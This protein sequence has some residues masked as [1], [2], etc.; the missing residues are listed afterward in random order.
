MPFFLPSPLQLLQ[1]SKTTTKLDGGATTL[2]S[3]ILAQAGVVADGYRS[4]ENLSKKMKKKSTR[5]NLSARR[6][7][8][9]RRDGNKKLTRVFPMQFPFIRRIYSPHCCRMVAGA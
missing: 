3:S 2:C 9:D 1:L 4:E 5:L 7:R 6:T 8:D